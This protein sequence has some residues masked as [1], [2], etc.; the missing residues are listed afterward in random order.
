[1]PSPPAPLPR[2]EGR[3][4]R[5][6][7]SVGAA[8]STRIYHNRISP[9]CEVAFAE[10]GSS[11]AH[12]CH[13][14]QSIQFAA[15]A[16]AASPCRSGGGGPSGG[17]CAGGDGRLVG[18]ARR[19]VGAVGRGGAGRAADRP[20]PG[21]TSIAPIGR[22]WPTCPESARC[23]R[24]GS[25][26]AG[27][28]AGRSPITRTCGGGCPDW[29]PGRSNPSDR[30]CIRCPPEGLWW[31]NDAAGRGGRKTASGP[32]ILAGYSVFNLCAIRG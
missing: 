26:I 14:R 5:S 20:L 31:G 3:R 22:N 27:A 6:P 4:Q 18:R 2:G 23:W 8:F 25:S 19:V 30:I 1:M 16:L 29:V 11:G 7:A 15:A 13:V 17:D 32:I 28:S 10:T 24:T 21:R 9:R 12:H